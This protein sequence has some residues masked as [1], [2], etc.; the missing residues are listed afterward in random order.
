MSVVE[1]ARQ[2]QR[3]EDAQIIREFMTTRA[4]PEERFVLGLVAKMVEQGW[5]SRV[6]KR[7][8]P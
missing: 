3:Q 4:R 5:V 1:E 6:A 2:R 7:Q 8:A